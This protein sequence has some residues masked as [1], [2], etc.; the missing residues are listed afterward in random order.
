MNGYTLH[1]IQCLINKFNNSTK[2]KVTN[3]SINIINNQTTKY[4][5]L[6]YTTHLSENLRKLLTKHDD[7]IRIGFKP[8]TTVNNRTTERHIPHNF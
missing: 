3:A 7:E 4:K 2:Q 1:L 8:H 5:R 6:T